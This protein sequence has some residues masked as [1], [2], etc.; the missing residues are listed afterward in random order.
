M[1]EKSK[2]SWRDVANALREHDYGKAELLALLSDLYK[3]SGDNR[4]FLH[5]RFSLGN[6]AL[7]PYLKIINAAVY[8]E[9][10]DRTDVR[11]AK[12]AISRYERA[13]GRADGRLELMFHFI[14]RGHKNVIE[15]GYADEGFFMALERM[16]DRVMVMLKAMSQAERISYQKRCEEIVEEVMDVG[17][18][19][20]DYLLDA[21]AKVFPKE[22]AKLAAKCDA[23]WEAASQ[24]KIIKLSCTS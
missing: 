15:C 7:G 16:F 20:Y 2:P 21:Y 13:I 12:Q 17:W 10:E 9:I 3:L 8:P 19:H 23:A 11:A 6:D 5:T 1:A 22:G 24:I 18:G 14:E 4:D